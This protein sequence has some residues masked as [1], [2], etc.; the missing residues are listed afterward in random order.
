MQLIL[1]KLIAI[2]TQAARMKKA[3]LEVT[4]GK[5]V[6]PFLPLYIKK[7]YSQTHS[8][9]PLVSEAYNKT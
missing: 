2:S 8:S 7:T 1:C 6:H 5:K 3:G 4:Q 9:S